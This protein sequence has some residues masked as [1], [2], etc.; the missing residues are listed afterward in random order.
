M[1]QVV[2]ADDHHL[3]RDGVRR[4][5]EIHGISVV[6]EAEDGA[7]AV[8]EVARLRP[9]VAVLDVSLPVHDGFIAAREIV[10]H[11]PET[12]V[13]FLSL[14]DDDRTLRN[15]AAAGGKA[16]VVKS[17]TSATLV[18]AV[19]AVAADEDLLGQYRSASGTDALS[20]LTRREL[21]VLRLASSGA[22][23]AEIAR[24]LYVSYKTAKN[25][26]ASIYDKLGVHGRTEAIVAGVRL[27]LVHLAHPS[28]RALPD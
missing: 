3:V 4:V 17:E 10:E 15:A 11:F 27:G 6:G 28:L 1:I 13:V 24:S 21:E 22:S 2:V 26:L 9:D 16:Y 5:L 25:H 18:N 14:F 12:R 23:T 7:A 19:R 20:L 8:S